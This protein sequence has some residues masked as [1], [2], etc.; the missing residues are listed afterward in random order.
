MNRFQWMLVM[1]LLSLSTTQK[2]F[3][4]ISNASQFYALENFIGSIH[5]Y[6]LIEAQIH[7]VDAGLTSAQRQLL[8]LYRHVILMSRANLSSEDEVIPVT[9]ALMMDGDVERWI[10]RTSLTPPSIHGWPYIDA[11][12]KRPRLAMVIPLIRSQVAALAIQ[13]NLSTIYRPCRTK[14]AIDLII[15][16]NEEP[17]SSIKS[18]IMEV[19]R[20][21]RSTIRT[22]YGHVHI[23]AADLA[24][25][26]DSYFL[27]SAIMW[28][29]LIEDSDP[30]SLRSL[31]Y[32]HFFIMETD[33]RP[34]R[35][36]WLD[37][38][39]EQIVDQRRDAYLST[40]WWMTGSIYRGSK[41]IGPSFI[42]INGNALYHLS[43]NFVAFVRFFWSIY[44]RASP[45]GYDFAIYQLFH[46]F[47]R[48]RIDLW[49]RIAHKFR[50]SEFIQ[51]CWYTG[52]DSNDDHFLAEFPQTY[53]IHSGSHWI[54]EPDSETSTVTM[55]QSIGIGLT[56]F[57]FSSIV[58]FELLAFSCMGFVFF[59]VILMHRRW[60]HYSFNRLMKLFF[61][62]FHRQKSF[63]W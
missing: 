4:T 48:D 45:Q 61:R 27:G 44:E 9:N 31:G 11:I 17:G 15:Y 23:F 28:R 32:T 63:Q 51:N 43:S 29:R 21:Y 16:H 37:G 24:G 47:G 18:E 40:S 42:H 36:F 35:S 55:A 1:H 49:K 3:T 34:I 62:F 19:L 59:V 12:Q 2:I 22:C 50:Y 25:S 30:L 38:I 53:L 33:T 13:F 10:P 5:S 58:L 8:S 56:N 57:I 6:P 20:Q 14:K 7:V 46:R 26:N 52:C 39:F 60:K 41:N 54:G